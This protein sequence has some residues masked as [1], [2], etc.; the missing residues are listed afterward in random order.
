V[1]KLITKAKIAAQIQWGI[2]YWEVHGFDETD[3]LVKIFDVPL[4][5]AQERGITKRL[6]GTKKMNEWLNSKEGLAYLIASMV[7]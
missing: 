1:T 7:R 2:S 5:V 6:N 4:R 3:K